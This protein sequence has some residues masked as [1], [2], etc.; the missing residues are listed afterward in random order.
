M[1]RLA[2]SETA[3]RLITLFGT[4]LRFTPDI[5]TVLDHVPFPTETHAHQ[6]IKATHKLI[7]PCRQPTLNKPFMYKGL[8]TCQA[9]V[10]EH[11]K[12]ADI[13]HEVSPAHT[14][15]Q[16][17]DRCPDLL[18]N[19]RP[20]RYIRSTSL[21]TTLLTS[22]EPECEHKRGIGPVAASGLAVRTSCSQIRSNSAR[23][24]YCCVRAR[25]VNP[26]PANTASFTTAHIGAADLPLSGRSLSLCLLSYTTCNSSVSLVVYRAY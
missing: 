10:G 1:L 20:R 24:R 14:T 26:E 4:G 19:T 13:L 18:W 6:M 11:I 7:L 12:K 5:D 3:A 8:L 2:T 21:F 16:R 9:S 25:Q 17:R 22:L 23:W 15:P